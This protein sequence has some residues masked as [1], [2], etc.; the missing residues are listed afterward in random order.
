MSALYAPAMSLATA[1]NRLPSDKLAFN[2]VR[3][4]WVEV[5]RGHPMLTAAQ[6]TV[7]LAIAQQHINHNPESPWF[8]SAWA[9]HQTIA[10]ETGLTRRTVVSAMVALKQMGLIA[11]EHGGGWKV[12]GGRTDRYTL[13]TDWLDVLE[14]AAQ[15][16]RKDVKNFHPPNQEKISQ[17]DQSGEKDAESGEIEDQMIGNSLS[18]DV[19]GLRTTL[20]SKTF[21]ESRS[22][23]ELGSSTRTD[24]QSLAVTLKAINGRKADSAGMTSLDQFALADILGEGNVERGYLRIGR[25]NEADANELALRYRHDRSSAQAV[26]AQAARLEQNLGRLG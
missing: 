20:S 9:A 26:R 21:L 18:D 7:G 1:I 14:L 6:R 12:P 13:R 19:K 22:K 5:V 24:P 2:K 17:F 16:R 10:T 11:I 23:T 25:L 3:Y 15:V 8:H 4:R